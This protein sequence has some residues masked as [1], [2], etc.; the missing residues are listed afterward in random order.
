M[1]KD[2]SVI[3]KRLPRMDGQVKA[4]GEAVYTTDLK[5][6]KM[7]HGKILRSPHPHAN[8]LHID[9]S[10]AERLP[11]IKGVITWKDLSTDKKSSH[12][13]GALVPDEYPL[14]IDR[15]RFIGDEVAAVA[16]V[17]E[18]IAR[19][20]LELIHVEYEPLPAVFDPIKA[21]EGGAPQL[22][23]HT[24]RNI[25]WRLYQD[26]GEVDRFLSEADHVQEDRFTT[27]AVC[28]GPLEPHAAVAQFDTNS[29]LTIW[30]STQRPFFVSWDVALALGLPE[31]RVRVIKP[32]VGGAFGGKLETSTVDYSAA[33]LARKTGRPVKIVLSHDEELYANRKRHP[34]IFDLKTG[35]KKDGTITARSCRAVMDG[36]AYNSVGIITCY[37]SAIFLN[38]PYRSKAIHY[39]ALRVYTNNAP[40]GAMRGFGAPQTHFAVEVQMDMIAE[41]L[42]MD[43]ME[44]RLKNALKAG[45][46]TPSG[47]K[48]KSGALRECMG[49]AAKRSQWQEKRKVGGKDMGIGMACTSFLS[50]PRNRRL[51]RQ[52]DA[53]AFSASL[54]R[55]HG[56]GNVTLISGS[57]DLGQGS[58]SAL[59]QI[60]AEELGISYERVIVLAGDTE[61]APL[62]FGSYGSRVT[63]M[64][65]NATRNAASALRERI[66][67]AVAD[68]LEANPNDLEIKEDLVT[69]KGSPQIK[70]SFSD[71]VLICQKSLGGRPVIGEGFYNPEFEGVL[72]M[73]ALCEHGVGNYSPAYSFG[74][75]VAEV[76][77]DAMSGKV[78]AKKITV[79]HD[80][81]VAINPMAVEGQLEGSVSMGHGYALMEEMVTKE[82]LMLNP[83]FLEYRM[84]T[85]MDATPVEIDLVET[86]DPEGPF[87]AKE[88]GEGLVSPTAPS[89]VN[90]IHDATGVWIKE[91]PVTPDKILKA[92]NEKAKAK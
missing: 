18:D 43:P 82:G 77:V 10:R 12:N 6:P 41:T 65:G 50:G 75:Q 36:G 35:V 55:A 29:G 31:S 52:G 25:S 8:I 71:A 30:S 7:L 37:L 58:D 61:I 19:E 88:A 15:V 47:I 42:G 87:G 54:I 49:S 72:D 67:D 51:P 48:I 5:L 73:K 45:D 3:G 32:H 4:T 13:Y 57:A 14:A 59:A 22:H 84:P 91:L 38:I 21:M 23:E 69:V 46:E 76:E 70:M 39:E 16:A 28:H 40:S 90:A 26:Q 27:Q 92:M 79:A 63:M 68:E 81:G 1:E 9:T 11:G 80:G 74:T 34:F 85:S 24:E 44:L 53:Y 83:G 17:D 66:L 86:D 64:A 78:H 60:A 56:D 62:D 20:A 89:I 2:Y 33:L